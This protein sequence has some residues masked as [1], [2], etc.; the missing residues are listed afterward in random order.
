[1]QAR[2]I[3]VPIGR[4]SFLDAH[5]CE[6]LDALDATARSHLVDNLTND[7]RFADHPELQVFLKGFRLPCRNGF[8]LPK[9][10]R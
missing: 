9:V 2:T 4:P 6:D 5:R 8:N 1:V 10:G 7:Y 3:P